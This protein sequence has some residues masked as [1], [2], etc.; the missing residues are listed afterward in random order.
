VILRVFLLIIFTGITWG[1]TI[2]IL[3]LAYC[4]KMG[5]CT[6]AA[7]TAGFSW[8]ESSTIGSLMSCKGLIELIV[9]NIGLSAGILTQVSDSA[10][11]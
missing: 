11:V 7:R 6:L 8:R 5:G 9:L 2:A 3:V 10:I 1:F 4:G